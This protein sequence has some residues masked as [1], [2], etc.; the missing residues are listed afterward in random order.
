MAWVKSRA[1]VK[2][3]VSF[4]AFTV[5]R[6]GTCSTELIDNLFKEFTARRGGW[7]KLGEKDWHIYTTRVHQGCILSPCLCNLHAEYIIWNARLDESQARI[8]I[9]RRNINN[10]RYAEDTTLKAESKA[11]LKSL[12]IKVKEESEKAGLKLS[13]QKAK[14]MASSP[15]TSWQIDGKKWRVT[16]GGG[17]EWQRNRMGRPLSPLQIHWKNS[18]MLSKLHKTTSDR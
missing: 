5:C 1:W 6:G 17:A 13:I 7:D 4:K 3:W 12:L 10:L 15:I 9:A 18:W 14:S 16:D 2:W 11:E 8:K